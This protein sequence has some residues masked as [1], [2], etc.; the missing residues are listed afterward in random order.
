MIVVQNGPTCGIYAWLNGLKAL[1]GLEK[2]T[3]GEMESLVLKLLIRNERTFK[4]KEEKGK[5]FVGEFFT[6]EDYIVFLKDNSAFV[7]KEIY[8]ITGE[9]INFNITTMPINESEKCLEKEENQKTMFI[10]S[11][12]PRNPLFPLR[13]ADKNKT[14]LHWISFLSK[15]NG[16]KYRVMDS[17]YR[18]RLRMSWKKINSQHKRLKGEKYYW[19]KFGRKSKKEDDI[20]IYLK[21]KTEQMKCFVSNGILKKVI[22][23]TGRIVCLREIPECFDEC[24]D[25]EESSEVRT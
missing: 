12:L 24:S 15:S 20:N 25:R 6:L 9:K 18:R 10:C 13:K 8:E 1:F 7:I 4:N 11:I 5:T 3:S 23:Q 17:R 14:I 16:H 21:F 22:Y 2:L 19:D